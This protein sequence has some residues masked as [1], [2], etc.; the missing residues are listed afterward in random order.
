MAAADASLANVPQGAIANALNAAAVASYTQQFGVNAGQSLPAA[1]ADTPVD[2]TDHW[3]NSG[4]NLKGEQFEDLS[5]GGVER[6]NDVTTFHLG[7]SYFCRVGPTPFHA[8]GGTYDALTFGKIIVEKEG[9]KP[10]PVSINLPIRSSEALLSAL[11]KLRTSFE[12]NREPLTFEELEVLK[13]Q[14]GPAC[15]INLEPR[16]QY[17]APKAG[18]K[19]DGNHVIAGESVTIGR[20]NSY[21]AITLC[22]LPKATGANGKPTKKFSLSFPLRF[23]PTLTVIAEFAYKTWTYTG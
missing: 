23:L 11:Q 4:I 12:T 9:G 22:R 17:V 20:G 21:E 1:T 8:Q 18:F 14:G 6:L 5:G 7:G 13:G 10:K 15:E 2:Y 19:I 3:T 16:L